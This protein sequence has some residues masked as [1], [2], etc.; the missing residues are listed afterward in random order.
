MEYFSFSF[1]FSVALSFSQ[2]EE[3]YGNLEEKDQALAKAR[4]ALH[5]AQLQKYQ[6]SR[7]S[8]FVYLHAS[9]WDSAYFVCQFSWGLMGILREEVTQTL[10]I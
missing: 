1:S 9:I 6:A 5:K 3:L 2:V 10:F 4:E 7:T 8:L